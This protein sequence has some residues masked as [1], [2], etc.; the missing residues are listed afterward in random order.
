MRPSPLHHHK[1]SF[2]FK[3][4]LGRLKSLSGESLQVGLLPLEFDTPLAVSGRLLTI[5]SMDYH[6]FN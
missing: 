5:D 1:T 2:C 4:N 6:Y 3:N